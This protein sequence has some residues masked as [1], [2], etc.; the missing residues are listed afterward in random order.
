MADE[1]VAKG[2]PVGAISAI[3]MGSANPVSVGCDGLSR[4]DL[5]KCLA[6]DRRVEVQVTGTTTT[7][8]QVSA[9]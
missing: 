8:E 9:Q 2:V 6:P 1:L 7:T 4:N 3:G 5:I